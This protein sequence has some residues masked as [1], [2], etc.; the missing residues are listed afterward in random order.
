M[1]GVLRGAGRSL[2]ATAV[3]DRCRRCGTKLR[4]NRQV[5]PCCGWDV[6]SAEQPV[7]GQAGAGQEE[8]QS[9]PAIRKVAARAGVRMCAI[10]MASV[11]EQEIVEH[12]GQGICPAC[13]E[14][15]RKKAG[16]KATGAPSNQ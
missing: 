1:G 15:I 9:A 5:C 13:A 6:A 10:C 16:R 7:M 11:P 3:P 2:V 12:E 14:G 4:K 8:G